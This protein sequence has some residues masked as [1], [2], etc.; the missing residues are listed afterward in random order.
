MIRS[1][2]Y[3]TLIVNIQTGALIL[4]Y[5]LHYLRNVQ[6]HIIG[7]EREC[8]FFAFFFF[9]NANAKIHKKTVLTNKI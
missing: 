4:L 8:A 5:S 9:Q 1:T 2:E 6:F 3:I 7:I